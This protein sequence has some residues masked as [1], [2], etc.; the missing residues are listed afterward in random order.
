[1]LWKKRQRL[2]Y[3]NDSAGQPIRPRNWR[4]PLP[5]H[6]SSIRLCLTRWLQRFETAFNRSKLATPSPRVHLR[7]LISD[8]K[9]FIPFPACLI[10]FQ[11]GGV[12][13]RLTKTP[14][15]GNRT[16]GQTARLPHIE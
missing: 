12:S 11:P 6:Y 2:S 5:I 8:L 4:G 10:P 14:T 9:A 16:A 15:R 1:A 3:S 7:T 13:G